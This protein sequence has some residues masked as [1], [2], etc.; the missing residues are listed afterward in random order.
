MLNKDNIRELAY[1]VR[2][3]NIVGMDADRLECAQING[4]N[5][6][7]GKGEFKPGDLAIYFEIDSQLPDVYPFN[8]MEFLKSKRYKIKSQKIRGV[9]SQGLLMPASAF[10]WQNA[11]TEGIHGDDYI[12]DPSEKIS[13]DT[14]KTYHEGD[15][16]TEKLG[17][18]YA[19]SEDNSRKANSI[20]KYKKMAQRHPD[21]AKTK[22]WRTLYKSKMGKKILFLFFGKK[23]DKRTWPAWVV[24]TDEE[25][26]QNIPW[27]LAE[28]G[29][30]IA[31]EKI[32]GTSTTFTMRRKKK[33][34]KDDFDFY[35][36]S[37]NVVFDKP[38]KQ[39]F[40]DTNY[41]TQMA[42]KYNVEEQL[43]HFLVVHPE[44]EWITLQGETY[45][46]GVQ[47]RDYSLSDVDFKGFN[48]ITS[49]KGRWNSIVAAEFA[50]TEF[51]IPWVPITNPAF[52]MPNTVEEL[53]SMAG[54]AS[55]VD[56]KPREGLVFRSLDGTKSFK[57]VSNEYLL[58]YHQ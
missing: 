16:L 30:W 41:Y 4:W 25:R 49:D 53:L 44:V 12:I 54:G 48:L 7:V 19:V 37:R 24:K 52:Y 8:E 15:F 57:A 33:L 42:E 29:P 27:I 34:F 35:V 31:T 5:C 43:R 6:V 47:K 18:T 22:W 2:V 9:V 39:C 20:D 51:H 11:Y 55:F 10:G 23:K 56:G 40:Y 45:G 1:V 17:V 26:I 50:N 21:L 46:S 32:D 14:F 3:N 36:C 38:D 28:K 58:K 13:K